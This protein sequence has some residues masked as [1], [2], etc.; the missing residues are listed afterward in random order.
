MSSAQS[1]A[2]ERCVPT[3]LSVLSKE[4]WIKFTQQWKEYMYAAEIV[5]RPSETKCALMKSMFSDE[6]KTT[7]ATWSG[8]WDK[9]EDIHD[10]DKVYDA[11]S[12][13]CAPKKSK[14]VQRIAL[15]SIIY[16]ESMPLAEFK[17]SIRQVQALCEYEVLDT[18]EKVHD[19]QLLE[20]IMT[21]IQNDSTRRRLLAEKDL[22][23]EKATE[24][25]EARELTATINRDLL[26]RAP[27]T[28]EVSEFH[29][30]ART[31]ATTRIWR[32]QPSKVKWRLPGC[33]NE[34]RK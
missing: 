12:T 19:A 18:I 13:H 6:I 5:N 29:T 16:P 30:D 33:A 22:D 1:F 20:R 24:I 28:L 34:Y 23:L 11:M 2:V 14:Y 21:C 31:R 17:S 15:N 9:E 4:N 32:R 7:M 8:C 25:I 26:Q 3:T 27:G 10:Y